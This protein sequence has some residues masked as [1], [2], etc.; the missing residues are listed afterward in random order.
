MSTK[1]NPWE[2]FVTPPRLDNHSRRQWLVN[3]Y[4]HYLREFAE[5]PNELLA[6]PATFNTFGVPTRMQS[7]QVT[8]SERAMHR[9]PA[10]NFD[11]E[12]T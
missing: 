2:T 9:A 4:G 7:Q 12:S 1:P 5:L 3:D 10:S 8:R 6:R 11:K